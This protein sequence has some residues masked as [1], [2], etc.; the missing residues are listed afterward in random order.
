[1]IR[2][3]VTGG[4]ACGKSTV[5]GLLAERGAAVGDAD[6]WARELLQPGQAVLAQVA[7]TFG[8]AVLAPDGSL[9]RN[10]LAGL[11]F[12]DGRARERLNAIVHPSARGR[13]QV[14]LRGL[15]AGTRVAAVIVPLLY[16]AGYEG[17]WDAVVCVSACAR[18]QR[19]RLAGRGLA[20]DEAGRRVAAQMELREKER[21]SDFVIVNNGSETTLASQ[22]ERILGEMTGR[23]HV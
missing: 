7:E 1:M 13:W 12:S 3:A 20:A 18:V 11:V 6:D 23:E 10:A 22:V 5:G 8:P 19:Q 4:I 21:R 16:E 15:P 2:I 14:W 9:D 17:G